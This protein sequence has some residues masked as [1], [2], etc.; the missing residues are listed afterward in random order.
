MFAHGFH[1]MLVCEYCAHECIVSLYVSASFKVLVCLIK[2]R[3][4]VGRVYFIMLFMFQ[5]KTLSALIEVE[6]HSSHA[7]LI[8][9]LGTLPKKKTKPE[10]NISATLS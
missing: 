8:S 6:T 5:T 3:C 1:D 2:P 9:T 4:Y 7:I 10:Q